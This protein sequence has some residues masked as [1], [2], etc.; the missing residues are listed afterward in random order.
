MLLKTRY[1]VIFLKIRKAVQ[2]LMFSIIFVTEIIMFS[3]FAR[4]FL[5]LMLSLTFSSVF[6]TKVV[7]A[8]SEE[9]AE[10]G[11]LKKSKVFVRYGPSTNH[12]IKWIYHGKGLPVKI[13]RRFDQWR[14]IEDVM[15]TNGWV[16][17]SLLSGKKTAL[18]LSDL[19][20][21]LMY[22]DSDADKKPILR[23]E[24]GLVVDID[25]CMND[26]CEA[27]IAGYTGFLEKKYLWG[28]E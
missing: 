22:H 20:Y 1:L 17:A 14:K 5:I 7:Y 18:I 28:I 2:K 9:K 13:T 15:G 10:Y 25:E 6:C 21:I 11:S 19:P 16:H 8:Q 23:L 24:P 4:L 27:S 12:P 3:R 26:M